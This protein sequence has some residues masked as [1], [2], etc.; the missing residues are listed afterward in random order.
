V[1][2]LLGALNT[3]LATYA[4]LV[5]VAVLVFAFLAVAKAGAARAGSRWGWFGLGIV[6][7]GAGGFVWHYGH[8]T[9]G[10][11]LLLVGLLVVVVAGAL[12]P[13]SRRG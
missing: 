4:V 12:G 1:A 13:R 2:D 8:T 3:E 11:V 9:A 5:V 7:V 10:P 6:A